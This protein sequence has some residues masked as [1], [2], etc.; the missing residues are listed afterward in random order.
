MGVITLLLYVPNSLDVEAV[1]A[2][3]QL[4]GTNRQ[5]HSRRRRV[6]VT[7]LIDGG[8]A[9]LHAASSERSRGALSTDAGRGRRELASTESGRND[10]VGH[11]IEGH[12]KAGTV[13]K[14]NDG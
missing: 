3:R 6:F 4:T 1:P 8:S 7:I 12:D 5:I 14:R 2:I 13:S 10:G 9:Y 11:G